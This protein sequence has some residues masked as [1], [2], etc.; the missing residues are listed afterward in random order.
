MKSIK[1]EQ[2]TDG[3][4]RLLAAQ[5]QLYSKAKIFQLIHLAGALVL[6]AAAPVVL[7]LAPQLTIVMAFVGGGWFLISWFVLD[8]AQDEKVRQAATIQEQFD[9][10]VFGLSWNKTLVG[11]QLLPELVN[12]AAAGFEGKQQELTD[13]YPD[14]D[15]LRYPLN[16]VNAQRANLVWDSRLRRD[17]AGGMSIITAALFGA[18]IVVSLIT[19]QGF[20]AYVL[21]VL[22]PSLAA[23]HE[24]WQLATSHRATAHEQERTEREIRQYAQEG[25]EFPTVEDCRRIQDTIFLNR[26]RGPLVPDRWYTWRK[27]RFEAD[28]QAAAADLSERAS[29]A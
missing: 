12:A 27:S 9:V 17:Y 19:D 22:L 14:L 6:Q 3:S 15:A 7:V 25:G 26:R 13:W 29:D 24:G 4:L 1:D 2:N 18:G 8:R 21:A 10:A 16:V 5:R 23:L 20:R 11:D 28:M